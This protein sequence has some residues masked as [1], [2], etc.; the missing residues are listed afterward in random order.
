MYNMKNISISIVAILLVLSASLSFAKSSK[1]KGKKSTN[2]TNIVAEFKDVLGTHDFGDVNIT[3]GK[4]FVKYFVDQNS[5]I[6]IV[7]ITG[8]NNALKDYVYNSLN[9]KESY[10]TGVITN[11]VSIMKFNFDL[12]SN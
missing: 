9:G 11:Q 2:Y 10:S 12:R 8:T 1:P 5:K 6:N 3:K 4:V 7:D